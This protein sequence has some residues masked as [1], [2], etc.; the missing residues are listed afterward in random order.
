M[1]TGLTCCFALGKAG[2]AEALYE[3][4]IDFKMD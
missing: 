3:I 4:F 1:H 2:D